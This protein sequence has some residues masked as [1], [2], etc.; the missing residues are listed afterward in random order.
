[1]IAIL[2]YNDYKSNGQFSIGL[3]EGILVELDLKIKQLTESYLMNLVGNEYF[4]YL[5]SLSAFT[6]NETKLFSGGNY[7]VD[8]KTYFCGGIKNVLLRMVYYA[9]INDPFIVSTNGNLIKSRNETVSMATPDDAMS[10][11]YKHWCEAARIWNDEVLD[12]I[13]LNKATDTNLSLIPYYELPIS[14]F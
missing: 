7:T 11:T 12:F 3:D 10:K 1:M 5:N 14:L 9:M 13:Y 8:S 2:T 6:A 4:A